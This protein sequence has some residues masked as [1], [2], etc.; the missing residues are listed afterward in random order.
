MTAVA[1]IQK[2]IEESQEKTAALFEEQRKEIA[3]TGQVSKQLQSD[4]QSLME[5]QKKIGTR[6]FDVE[7]NRVKGENPTEKTF[8]ERVA[9]DVQ[10]SWNGSKATI[11][12]KSFVEKAVTSAAA[13]A[14]VLVQPYRLPGIIM[15]GLQRLTVRQLLAQGRIESNSLEYVRENVFTN[16]AA[17]VAEGTLKPESNITFTKA[18][19]NV[20]T[21][22]HWIQASR[23][24]IDDASLLESYINERM[25]YGL[26]LK[27]EGQLLNGDGTG[28]NL[29]GL[30]NVATAYDDDLNAAGDTMVDKLAHAIYQVS[31][32]EFE[33]TGVV[34]HPRDWHAISLLK[35]AEGRYILGGP[36]AFASRVLWGLP[37]VPTLSQARGQFTVGG[38]SYAS[39]VFD[40]MDATVELSRED[41]DNFVKNMITIL[42]EERL[43]VAHYRPQAIVKGALATA[44]GGE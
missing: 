29:V 10:K 30:N 24:I 8:A 37:V 12:V 27:E 34:L 11:E 5:E 33:A 17:P 4:F 35:D 1:E 31:E 26:A 16:S 38:F 20:K 19:A 23:Q 42:C 32:S 36:Q 7:Q 13:S 2:A 14:G 3:T 18:T 21:I 9:A 41:R 39:Q 25:M 6:L 22:A 44:G 28:D 43:A 40:R 15:P